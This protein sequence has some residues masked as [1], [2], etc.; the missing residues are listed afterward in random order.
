M[1]S[2]QC[3]YACS[4]DA[5]GEL[6]ELHTCSAD[7]CNNTVHPECFATA[8]AQLFYHIAAGFWFGSDRSVVYCSMCGV[9]CNEMLKETIANS[10]PSDFS[11]D[12]AEASE[13]SL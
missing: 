8:T 2:T 13:P 10:A 6:G 4:A 7:S 12:A 11:G 9:R 1:A 3:S 5:G